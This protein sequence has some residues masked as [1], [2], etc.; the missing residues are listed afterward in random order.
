[1]GFA[2]FLAKLF[3]SS[4]KQAQVLCIGL[5]N[6][7]KSTI[8]NHLKP[9]ED[10]TEDVVAT[11]GFSVEKFTTPGVSFTVFDMSGQGKYRD[12]WEHYYKEAQA[13]IFVID[14]SDKLRIVVAKSEIDMLL[15]HAAVQSRRIPILFFANKM[16]LRDALTSVKCIR[17][18][19]LDKI[20]DKPW[21]ICASNA[22]TGE[23]LHEGIQWLSEQLKSGV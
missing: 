4:K 14:S 11:V 13:V 8:I 9:N 10:Q 5:D 20:K 22:L 7:G 21:H 15:E 3:G 17:L 2:A 1:M 18:L 23:G 19:E 16:D 6:S 12:L